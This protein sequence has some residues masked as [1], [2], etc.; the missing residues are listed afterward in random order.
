MSFIP[1]AVRGNLATAVKGGAMFSVW[2][3][4]LPRSFLPRVLTMFSKKKMSDLYFRNEF[5][6]W[7]YRK[8]PQHADLVV[9]GFKIFEGNNV[10]SPKE[11]SQ[12][13]PDI[14]T[15]AGVFSPRG[16]MV[17]F[18]SGS[19][20]YPEFQNAMDEWEAAWP[21]KVTRLH[22][23]DTLPGWSAALDH[24]KELE[25]VP[26]EEKKEH[27]CVTSDA[28]GVFHHLASQ[29]RLVPYVFI[30]DNN[31]LIRWRSSWA[32]TQREIEVIN[33]GYSLD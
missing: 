17:I 8:A 14:N 25:G 12:A 26:A 22:L 30:V 6:L 15:L 9:S 16:Q 7:Q 32:P 21:G 11:S 4:Y 31:G 10:Y 13:F 24:V 27:F 33:Q 28:R 23:Q 20:P 18:T 19:Y 2:D 5:L 3:S 1:P 29:N